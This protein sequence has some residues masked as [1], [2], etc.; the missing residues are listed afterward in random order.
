[1]SNQIID[2][3][4]K[5]EKIPAEEVE[6]LSQLAK[7]IFLK[8]GEFLY[9]EGKV[10]KQ[11]AFILSGILREFYTDVKNT[12]YIRRFYFKNWWAV[13][14][15]ELAYEKPAICSVQAIKN[16]ELLTFT[17]EDVDIMTKS[18]PV[19]TRVLHEISSAEKYSLAK[20][21]KEKRSLTAIENYKNLLKNSSEFDKAIPLF[22][23][24]SYLNIQPESLSRI[25]KQLN[26]N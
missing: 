24:A 23:I 15:Y 2:F 25:R 3:L 11:G 4:S 19:A 1:M 14:M 20:K 12:D 8:K 5:T 13:D 18:C 9:E 26:E 7:P 10:P 16:A 21:E 22:H 6:I 17:K